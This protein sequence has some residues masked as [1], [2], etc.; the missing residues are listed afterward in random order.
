M[1]RENHRRVNLFGARRS[2]AT[3][4]SIRYGGHEG[5]AE[6]RKGRGTQARHPFNTTVPAARFKRAACLS[7]PA[8]TGFGSPLMTAVADGFGNWSSRLVTASAL[9]N[10]PL[11]VAPIVQPLPDEP[12]RIVGR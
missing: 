8:L 4:E 12:E 6:A 1:A 7:P 3:P 2:R 11:Q 9:S 5:R 10:D